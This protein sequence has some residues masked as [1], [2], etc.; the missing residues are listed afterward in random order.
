MIRLLIMISIFELSSI[1][2]SLSMRMAMIVS[3]MV[4][5]VISNSKKK[6]SYDR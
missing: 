1:G 3:A 6:N 4:P 5:Q 2:S